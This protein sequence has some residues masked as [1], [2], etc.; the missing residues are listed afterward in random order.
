MKSILIF[1]MLL[2]AACKLAAGPLSSL[3]QP[4]DYTT[5]RLSSFDPT[6]GNNDGGQEAF[7]PGDTRVIA[8]ITGNGQISHIWFTLAPFDKEVLDNIILRIWWDGAEKPS[9]EAPFGAFFGL[10]HGKIHSFDSAFFSIGNQRG[11]NCWLPM[12]FRKSA[13]ITLENQSS[14]TLWAVYF[15]VNYQLFNTP[16]EDLHWFHAHYHQEKPALSRQNFTAL[17]VTGRGHYVGMFYYVRANSGGWW[18]EGDDMIYIDGDPEPTLHGT[19]MEDYF[20]AA[21]GMKESENFQRFGSPLWEVGKVGEGN[22]NTAYRWHLEDAITFSKSIRV[23]HE[24]GSSNERNDD[25]ASVAFV[26]L[27]TIS[28]AP[29]VPSLFER[30]SYSAKKDFLL[31]QGDFA[32]YEKLV[33][34]FISNAVDPEAVNNSVYSL[35]VVLLERNEREKAIELL[36]KHSGPMPLAG[37]TERLQALKAERGLETLTLPEGNIW[38]VIVPNGKPTLVEKA[39]R[40]G[41]SSRP[42]LHAE[43]LYLSVRDD[44]LRGDDKELVLTM[45]V[46]S[47]KGVTLEVEYN[48]TL[49]GEFQMDTRTPRQ[50]LP[51]S[52]QWRK[53]TFNLPGASLRGAHY[54]GSDIRIHAAG[55]DF[56][57]A[58]ATV[59][60]R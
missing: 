26:Y 41:Y 5:H 38:H 6:G 44:S 19:G 11:V 60:A 51:G 29:Q 52:S 22:E 21:W 36:G 25:F 1:V 15:Y 8:D 47:E 32:A 50:A 57:I 3:A 20:S 59:Q 31:Q 14:Q 56:A 35:A 37:W 46:F 33:T 53:V 10:G 54:G 34:S 12:P 48:A 55:G 30:K 16:R 58:S 4:R 13:R 23:T 9:V 17:D 40:M 7:K 2:V 27:D 39:G 43:Y 28:P 45:D 24:K 18:G 42:D 49:S